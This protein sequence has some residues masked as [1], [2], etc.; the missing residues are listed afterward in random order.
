M[1]PFTNAA[2]YPNIFRRST[3]SGSEASKASIHSGDAGFHFETG[4]R[5]LLRAI[6]GSF[7]I[8]R[9]QS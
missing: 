6:D 5:L 7:E 2:G 1:L 3:V 9:L 4:D 8:D